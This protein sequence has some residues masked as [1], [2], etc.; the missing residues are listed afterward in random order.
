LVEGVHVDWIALIIEALSAR[1]LVALALKIRWV[2]KRNRDAK[3]VGPWM[4]FGSEE[5]L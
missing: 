4:G 5:I 2:L 1:G 3:P